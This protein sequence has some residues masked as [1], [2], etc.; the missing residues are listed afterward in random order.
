LL[1]FGPAGV[2]H[3]PAASA[4]STAGWTTLLDGTN[5]NQFTPIGNANWRVVDGAVQADNAMPGFLVSKASYGDFELRAEFWVTP[6]ANSGIF[7]R[8]ENPKEVTAMNAYEVNI[9][10]MR[11]DQ[12]YRTGGI[13]DVA[14]PLSIMNAGNRWNTYEITAKGPRLTVR[15]NGMP[16]VDVQDMKHARGPIALQAGAGIVKFRSVQIR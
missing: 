14:K 5:W 9:Y 8:C 16:M 13:V 6:D 4:Q 3:P 12:A 7:I 2:N 15:L 10:D 11:P 1:L